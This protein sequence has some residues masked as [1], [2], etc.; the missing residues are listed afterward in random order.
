MFSTHLDSA[1][2]TII[3]SSLTLCLSLRCTAD[4]SQADALRRHEQALLLTQQLDV[5]DVMLKPED[6][7]IYSAMKRA[8]LQMAEQPQL[9]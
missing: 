6:D 8:P 2:F 7:C 9:R 5:I 1:P 3:C 4:R